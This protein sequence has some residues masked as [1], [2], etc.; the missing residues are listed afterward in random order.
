MLTKRKRR[1]KPVSG[2][3]LTDDKL[4]AGQLRS[5]HREVQSGFERF[6]LLGDKLLKALERIHDDIAD[7]RGAVAHLE[8]RVTELEAR[9]RRRQRSS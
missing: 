8:K 6:G 3:D 4:V 9:R 7:V 5:L 1:F 2:A